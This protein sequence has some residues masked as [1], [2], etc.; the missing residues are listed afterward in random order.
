[1]FTL[2]R[3]QDPTVA[4]ILSHLVNLGFGSKSS[5]KNKCRVR[6]RFGLENEVRLYL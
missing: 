3:H 2:I 6:A 1:M 4:H 5:F